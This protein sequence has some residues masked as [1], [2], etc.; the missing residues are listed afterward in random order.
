MEVKS[1]F[2]HE[3]SSIRLDD[4]EPGKK[5]TIPI[6]IKNISPDQVCLTGFVGNVV[7]VSNG[8][9]SH[10]ADTVLG[11]P[12]MVVGHLGQ[13]PNVQSSNFMIN[14]LMTCYIVLTI[15]MLIAPIGVALLP[16][17]APP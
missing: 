6:T 11:P 10:V 7:K 12:Q 17:R 14:L 3:G 5:M 8:R 4:L 13:G 1:D 9:R 16:I 2:D 15:G